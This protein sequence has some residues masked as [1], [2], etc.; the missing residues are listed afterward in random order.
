MT[1]LET[2]LYLALKAY[3]R[4]GFGNSTDFHLQGAAYDLAVEAIAAA[5]AAQ[6]V[7]QHRIADARNQVVQSGY[8]CM[9]CGAL[10][11]AADH[12]ESQQPASTQPVAA[13]DEV[14]LAVEAEREAC[15][16]VC[17][18]ERVQW[19]ISRDGWQSA[20]DCATAIR[21]RGNKHSQSGADSS[22]S[23]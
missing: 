4:A 14:R 3:Y 21:A 15:A 1:E 2:K 10:F 12:G 19:D 22:A 17:E 23:Q 9:D 11:S 7:C 18:M 13:P 6:P 5:E 20:N 8:L 16:G